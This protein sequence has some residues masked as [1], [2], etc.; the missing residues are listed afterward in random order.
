MEK[1][2]Q[3]ADLE[4]SMLAVQEG[5]EAVTAAMDFLTRHEGEKVRRIGPE[6]RRRAVR[7]LWKQGFT[8]P[9]IA[10]EL[11]IS[12]RYVRMILNSPG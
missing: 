11:E 7:R 5:M 1:L 9:Q 6:V 12:E 3:L 10:G 2:S 8:T 4:R